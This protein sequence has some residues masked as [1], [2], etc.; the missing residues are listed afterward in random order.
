M[1]FAIGRN[2]D[3]AA[4]EALALVE[5]GERILQLAVVRIDRRVGSIKGAEL[6]GNLPAIN[7]FGQRVV[8]TST[9]RP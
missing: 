3:H 7:G 4:H 9:S 8:D 5:I 2:P 1:F 6:A